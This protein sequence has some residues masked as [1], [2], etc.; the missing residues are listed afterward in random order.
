MDQIAWR[1]ASD[2]SQETKC[3]AL[4]DLRDHEEEENGE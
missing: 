1:L 3:P 4:Q 2:A